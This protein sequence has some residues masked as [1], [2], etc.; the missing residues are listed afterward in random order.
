M[1]KKIDSTVLSGEAHTLMLRLINVSEIVAKKLVVWQSNSQ[2][3][4]DEILSIK[5]DY[6]KLMAEE[7]K[8]V[9]DANKDSDQDTHSGTV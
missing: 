5:Q 4:A 1:S 3:W 6:Y 8:G 7:S 2:Q 9:V